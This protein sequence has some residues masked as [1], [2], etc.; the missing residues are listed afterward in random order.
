MDSF[1]DKIKEVMSERQ[2]DYASPSDNHGLT[3]AMFELWMR[4]A[5]K[6]RIFNLA[7]GDPMKFT[8]EDVCVFNVIQKL[9]RM[10]YGTHDDS[11]LDIVG[12]AE[13]VARLKDGQRNVKG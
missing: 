2:G 12:Y 9:S 5:H 10:A 11:W 3:A 4:S 1:V 7:D 8:A 13:N 6:H